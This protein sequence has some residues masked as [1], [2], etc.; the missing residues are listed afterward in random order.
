MS[1]GSAALS[2]CPDHHWARFA[3]R[4]RYFAYFCFVPFSPTAEPSPGLAVEIFLRSDLCNLLVFDDSRQARLDSQNIFLC[5]RN[6]RP[7][8]LL[9][10]AVLPIFENPEP[11]QIRHACGITIPYNISESLGFNGQ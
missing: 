2:P 9:H 7:L 4:Q 11:K 5:V 1:P 6:S 10:E 8:Y 3:R